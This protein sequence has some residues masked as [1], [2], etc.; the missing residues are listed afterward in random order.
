MDKFKFSI[1]KLKLKGDFFC[2]MKRNGTIETY[3]QI[4]DLKQG[5][6]Q[7]IKMH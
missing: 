5:R 2:Y 7:N 4:F 3:D 1:S 6:I